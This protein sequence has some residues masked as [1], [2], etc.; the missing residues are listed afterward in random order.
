MKKNQ[1]VFLRSS[2]I[3]KTVPLTA[4]LAASLSGCVSKATYDQDISTLLIKLQRERADNAQNVKALEIKLQERGKS[5]SEITNR[6][7]MLQKEREQ[8]YGKISH[9]RADIEAIQRD[10]AELKLVIFTNVKGSEGNEMI[11]KIIDMQH[12]IQTILGAEKDI[13]TPAAVPAAQQ[14]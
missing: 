14:P 2:L 4:V 10:L 1:S 8:S 3:L 13:S 5:L 6:L 9:F 11:I 12:R 7:I